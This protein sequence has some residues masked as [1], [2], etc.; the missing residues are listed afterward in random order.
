MVSP[1][2]SEIWKGTD[3]AQITNSSENRLM[4]VIGTAM[5]WEDSV[6]WTVALS[7]GY[8]APMTEWIVGSPHWIVDIN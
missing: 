4:D 5:T 8:E 6:G 7:G 3:P 2:V 1:P